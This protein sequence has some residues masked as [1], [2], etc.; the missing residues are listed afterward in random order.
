MMEMEFE[1]GLTRGYGPHDKC[2]VGSSDDSELVEKDA[3]SKLR[4]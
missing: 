4:K 3:A 1:L 2:K